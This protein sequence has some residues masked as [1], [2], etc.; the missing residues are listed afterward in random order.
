L[1]P[2]LDVLLEQRRILQ[3]RH[4]SVFRDD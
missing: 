3:R 1:L 4:L 2:D